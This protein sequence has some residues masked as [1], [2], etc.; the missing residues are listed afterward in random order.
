MIR[1][2]DIIESYPD[3]EFIKAD[4]FDDAIIGIEANSLRLVY[5]VESAVEILMSKEG[6]SEDDALEY[7]YFNTITAYVGEKT[8]IWVNVT[9]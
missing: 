2:N 5:S 8:P 4:G 6:M 1:L 3:E 9:A 7:L